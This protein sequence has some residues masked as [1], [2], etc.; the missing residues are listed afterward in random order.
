MK[1][2]H[3]EIRRYLPII[4]SLL[5]CAGVAGTAYAAVIN[6]KKYENE[7]KEKGYKK[8]EFYAVGYGK[9]Y[10][11]FDENPIEPKEKMLIFAKCYYPTFI[12]GIST[13]GCIIGSNALSHRSQAGL[14]SAYGLLSESFGRYKNKVIEH[15]GYEEHKKIINELA[16]EDREKM[17]LY[18]YGAFSS[19]SLYGTL[20]SKDDRVYP[21]HDAYSNRWFEA[22]LSEIIEAEYHINRNLC[23]GEVVLMNDYYHFLGLEQTIEGNEL[24][25]FLGS[26]DEYYWIDFSN[27]LMHLADGTEYI[28]IFFE[29]PPSTKW[30]E[31]W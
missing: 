29:Y 5:G 21:V 6:T 9:P 15:H 8:T 14:I 16:L 10:V 30:Q 12:L 13:M 23:L 17:D 3:A 1:R 20:I 19:P 2:L 22:T 11:R 25:W 27:E 4:L 31:E 28:E 26:E 24:G 7:I 18:V